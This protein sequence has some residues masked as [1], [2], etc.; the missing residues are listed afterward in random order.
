MNFSNLSPIFTSQ[1][2]WSHDRGEQAWSRLEEVSILK[3]KLI[4]F[5]NGCNNTQI[6]QSWDNA[7]LSTP[8]N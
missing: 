3:E 2:V 4:Y 1:L 5:H 7:Y 6:K 8:V